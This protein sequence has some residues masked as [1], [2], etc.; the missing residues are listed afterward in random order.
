MWNK[1]RHL[2]NSDFSYGD[3]QTENWKCQLTYFGP[4][5]SG[6]GG[7][8]GAKEP[9]SLQTEFRRNIMKPG[10]AMSEN[11]IVSHSKYLLEKDSQNNWLQCKD[12]IY[13]KM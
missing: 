1:Q 5:W 6:M 7:L 10:L 13:S 4:L 3:F 9:F 12:H 2:Q 8:R 11:T